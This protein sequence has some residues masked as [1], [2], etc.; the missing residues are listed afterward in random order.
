[1]CFFCQPATNKT[2]RKDIKA[3]FT[4]SISA[5]FFPAADPKTYSVSSFSVL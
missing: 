5:I 2:V 3:D 4:R 1:M